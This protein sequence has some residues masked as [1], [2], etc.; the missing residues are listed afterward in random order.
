MAWRSLRTAGKLA[1]KR[2]LDLRVE[3]AEL[4]PASGP[5]IVAAHHVH[6]LYDGCALLAT[7]SRPLHIL[8]ALDWVQN[9]AGRLAMERLCAAARWPVVLRRDG[10]SAVG[11]GSAAVALRHALRES[12]DLLAEGRLVV[13]FPEAY[14]GIDPGFTPKQSED[15]FLPF[16]PG[17]AKLALLAARRGIVAPVVP[18]GFAYERGDRWRATLRF[19]APISIA[20]SDSIDGLLREIETRVRCLSGNPRSTAA[21]TPE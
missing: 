14:P 8:V 18:A 1:I 7:V 16:R 17:I 13:V 9:T 5:A 21:S 11:E 6:H 4:V 2:G 19:G 3:G 20:S 12:L 15:E 10:P